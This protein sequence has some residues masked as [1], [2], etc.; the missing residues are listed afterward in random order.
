MNIFDFCT[1]NTQLRPAII[2]NARHVRSDG[3]AAATGDTGA[4]T[5][6]TS[7]TGDASVAQ[8]DAGHTQGAT[9]PAQGATE[10]AKNERIFT[11]DEVTR[12]MTKEKNEGRNAVLNELGVTDPTK[13]KEL[14]TM[15]QQLVEAGKT[16]EQKAAEQSAEST[17]AIAD[18]TARAEA[19]EQKLTLT[20][21]GANADTLND[22][23]TL[24]K[25]RVTD[26]VD[27]GQAV[28]AVKAAYPA[29]F[30]GTQGTAGTG[31]VGSTGKAGQGAALSYGARAAAIAKLSQGDGKSKFFTNN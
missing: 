13:A 24:A 21:A 17:Q 28:E 6:Q 25:A 12:M 26:G 22:V 23:L 18:A 11:Q 27:F 1:G 7:S 4:A 20:L 31:A 15:A 9:P 19:A 5:G 16:P 2:H 14:L 3:G 8:A 10:A 30:G 29:M